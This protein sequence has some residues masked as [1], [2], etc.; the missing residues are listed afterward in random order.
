MHRSRIHVAQP[1]NKWMLLASVSACS[2]FVLFTGCGGDDGSNT[3]AQ[4][5]GTN[6]NINPCRCPPVGPPG[7]ITLTPDDGSGPLPI[8]LIDSQN[9]LLRS[10]LNAD[11]EKGTFI[12]APSGDVAI[13]ILIPDTAGA[14]RTVNLLFATSTQGTYSSDSLGQGTFTSDKP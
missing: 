10:D 5:T 9:Y 13:L 7:S 11:G 4:H 8:T 14:T 3:I 12:F 6:E 1:M 2:L